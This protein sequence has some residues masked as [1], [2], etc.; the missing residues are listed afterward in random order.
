MD[1]EQYRFLRTKILQQQADQ[2]FRT[3]LVTSPN[4]GEGKSLTTLNLALIF[5]MLPSC[6]VLIVEGDLRKG[7][8]KDWLGI[9]DHPGL[10]N[11]IDGSATLEEVVCRS[12]E[13]PVSFIVGGNSKSSPPELLHSPQ[14]SLQ[15]QEMAKH[16]DLVL[17][18]SPPVNV[19]ADAQLLAA[20]CEAILLVVRA[21]CTSEGELEE[22]AKKL[23][24]FRVIGTMLNGR[25]EMVPDY[26]YHSY[27]DT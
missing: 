3:L 11:L 8:L 9:Q 17:L 20:S 16:F 23:R 27:Y 22:A 2:M 25:Q 15:L 5:A 21:F 7:I 14:V 4:V 1:V 10:G 26:G 6:K 18:D 19:V 13:I 12:R 24:R